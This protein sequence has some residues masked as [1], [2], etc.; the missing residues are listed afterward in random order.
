[1][2]ELTGLA[3][4]HVNRLGRQAVGLANEVNRANGAVREANAEIEKANQII[5]EQYARIQELELALAVKEAEA[6]AAVAMFMD[7]KK[8][9][10]NSPILR[11]SG[12][13]FKNGGAKTMG[14]LVYE[15]EFD[16]ILRDAR[17]SNPEKYRHD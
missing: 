11:D 1:M 9:C 10:P 17:I 4:G 12:Q 7:I 13:K 15:R 14:R 2:D 16:R 3:L 5:A 8:A 6:G